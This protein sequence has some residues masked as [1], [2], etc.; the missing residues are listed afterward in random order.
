MVLVKFSFLCYHESVVNKDEQEVWPPAFYCTLNT[1]YRIVS[2]RIMSTFSVS[3][4][5]YSVSQKILS[6]KVF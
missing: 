6:P 3:I 1:H 2:Y 4:S 5:I